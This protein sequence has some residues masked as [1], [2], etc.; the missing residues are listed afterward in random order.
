MRAVA[1]PGRWAWVLSGLVTAAVLV[2]P[3][4]RLITLRDG[5][6]N[7]S[8]EPQ[9]VTTRTV[10]VPQP[11]TSLIVQSGGGQV[12]VTAGH[13][14]RV[15]VTET[16]MY[17]HQGDGPPAVAQSVSGGRLSLSD[18][19]CVNSD[20]SV[21]F[22]LTVPFGVTVSVATQ[23]G[24]AAVSGVAGANLDTGGGPARVSLIGG[25]LTV[26]TGGGPLVLRGVTGPLRADTGGGT[27]LAQDVAA[28]T[29]TVTTGGG[30]AMVT[31]AAAPESVSVST[32]GGPA[33][34]AVPGGP[35]A[36]AADS[37]GGPQSVAIATD[38]DAR[39]TLAITSGGRPLRIEPAAGP[40]NRGSLPAPRSSGI[41]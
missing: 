37:D 16:I 3:G 22:S 31:F 15:Q 32:D 23:G 34:L 38:P 12:Q 28:A 18:P 24:P 21:D 7:A 6:T 1:G 14:S 20:C 10:T 25:P 17:D 9:A 5:L 41:T 19:A 4:A 8:A 26:S 33:I 27:L 35:Y 11:V 30:P 36:V 39:P 2:V 13:V 40:G 29:A